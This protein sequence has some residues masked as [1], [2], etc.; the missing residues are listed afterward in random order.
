MGSSPNLDLGL[1]QVPAHGFK[2]QS[3]VYDFNSNWFPS[4]TLDCG[5]KRV[6]LD[7]SQRSEWWLCHMLEYHL[8]K[9]LDF[10]YFIF[11]ICKICLPR[12]ESVEKELEPAHGEHTA[13][14]RAE[15]VDLEV[16]GE[17]RAAV[18]QGWSK[19]SNSEMKS[20]ARKFPQ[21]IL[22]IICRWVWLA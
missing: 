1:V 12:P 16:M 13:C 11:L 22:W 17:V 5:I 14:R 21:I 9:S 10:L 20:L 15:C 4:L 8:G 2:S 7:L 19:G 3:E 18:L 6:G